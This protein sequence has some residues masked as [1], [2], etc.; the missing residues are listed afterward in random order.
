MLDRDYRP[1][2]NQAKT[3]A[4]CRGTSPKTT[5]ALSVARS[6]EDSRERAREQHKSFSDYPQRERDYDH[7]WRGAAVAGAGIGTLGVR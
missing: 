7:V 5:Q 1:R 2:H 4:S 3:G 6:V